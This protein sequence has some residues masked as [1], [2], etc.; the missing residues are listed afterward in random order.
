[1]VHFEPGELLLFIMKPLLK[2]YLKIKVDIHVESTI[3]Q[4]ESISMDIHPVILNRWKAELLIL[5]H[6][7][8]YFVKYLKWLK[9]NFENSI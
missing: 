6:D 8:L 7:Q 3:N 2:Y 4:C 9:L 5:C 1:M